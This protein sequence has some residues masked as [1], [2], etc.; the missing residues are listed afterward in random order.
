MKNKDILA[1]VLAYAYENLL[2]DQEAMVQLFGQPGD[3][4]IPE[5]VSRT[6]LSTIRQWTSRIPLHVGY[7]EDRNATHLFAAL[8]EEELL[9]IFYQHILDE[10][11]GEPIP[12]KEWDTVSNFFT[13]RFEQYDWDL[14]DLYLQDDEN[15]DTETTNDPGDSQLC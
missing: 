3:E 1:K 2:D 15:T 9:D 7:I 13:V 4:E 5:H 14:Y 12:D 10:Q 8:D 6:V 11:K